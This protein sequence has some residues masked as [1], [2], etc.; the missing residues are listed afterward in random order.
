M[1]LYLFYANSNPSLSL[2]YGKFVVRDIMNANAMYI[3]YFLLIRIG[4]HA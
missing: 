4:I 3:H 1:L 2:K